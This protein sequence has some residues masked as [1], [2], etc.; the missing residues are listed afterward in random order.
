MWH[1]CAE[2]WQYNIIRSELSITWFMFNAYSMGASF[3]LFSTFSLIFDPEWCQPPHGV[4]QHGQ[5][6]TMFQKLRWVLLWF[7][8]SK[9]NVL[10][11][12]GIC[13]KPLIRPYTFFLLLPKKYG[14][15]EREPEKRLMKIILW[16]YFIFNFLKVHFVFTFSVMR[17]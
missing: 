2:R 9:E 14:K 12:I 17:F 8:I 5:H 1:Q 6:R 4:Y 13:I 7:N 16:F 15:N 11:M 3:T 10:H